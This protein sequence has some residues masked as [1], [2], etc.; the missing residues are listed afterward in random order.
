M[1]GKRR[2]QTRTVDSMAFMA[3]DDILVFSEDVNEASAK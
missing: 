3:G 1:K 2:L